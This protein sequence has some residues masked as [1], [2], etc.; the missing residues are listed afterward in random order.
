MT[1]SSIAV[2]VREPIRVVPGIYSRA[3]LALLRARL[4]HERSGVQ[5]VLVQDERIS[6][7]LDRDALQA[8]CKAN[9]TTALQMVAENDHFGNPELSEEL[10]TLSLI[11]I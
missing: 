9:F 1:S 8:A 3:A 7:S 10:L 6:N 11:H 4:A 2:C 5:L